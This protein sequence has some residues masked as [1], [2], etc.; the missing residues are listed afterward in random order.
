MADNGA[1]DSPVHAADRLRAVARKRDRSLPRASD[2]V[3]TQL[4]FEVVPTWDCQP[5]S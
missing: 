4:S 3:I 5:N 1:S 2:F